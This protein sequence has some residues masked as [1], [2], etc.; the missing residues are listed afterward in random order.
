MSG[1]CWVVS[2]GSYS[3]YQV[4]AI[5]TAQEKAEAYAKVFGGD[6]EEFRLDRPLWSIGRTRHI[7]EVEMQRDGTVTRIAVDP[8]AIDLHRI[9]KATV[10]FRSTSDI[11][12]E[13][14]GWQYI[15]SR[16]FDDGSIGYHYN[17]RAH[18]PQRVPARLL[19][20][21]TTLVIARSEQHAIK[22]ANE[23]RARAIA[24]G[25]APND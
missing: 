12:R 3:D 21:M 17:A 15:Y 7:Y 10:R 2:Q 20:P 9:R 1:K 6:I 8:S 5:F 13:T 16:Y 18:P 19:W 4:D 14:D 22:V 25:T 24:E 11:Y 23:R